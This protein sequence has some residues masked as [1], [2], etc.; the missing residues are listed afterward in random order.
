MKKTSD[1]KKIAF[2]I[3]KEKGTIKILPKEWN[4]TDGS[5]GLSRDKLKDDK[6]LEGVNSNTSFEAS[7]MEEI[8]GNWYFNGG[9]L[10]HQGEYRVAV[11]DKFNLDEAI[12]REKSEK[13]AE[14]IADGIKMSINPNCK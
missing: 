9:F 12:D 10:G 8:N 6:N 13:E 2:T 7:S 4:F 3:G 1:G 14:A 11:S 5:I